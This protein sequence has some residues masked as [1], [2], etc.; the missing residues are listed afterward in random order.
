MKN[1]ALITG[2]TSGIGLAI[3]KLLFQ[4]G[5]NLILVG[6]TTEKLNEARA[7]FVDYER[8]GITIC[9]DLSANESAEV[10]YQKC[11]DHEVKILVNNAG[12]GEFGEHINIPIKKTE[13]MLVLNII[14]LTKLCALFGADFKSRHT[15]Y[16]L[17]IASTA[18]YQPVPRF[19]AYAASKSYV[20]N[21]TEALSK[22]L[23]DYNVVVTCLSPGHTETSFFNRA[24]I[25]DETNGF[26]SMKTRMTAASVA[27]I[28]VDALFSRKLSVIPGGRNKALAFLNK[29]STRN[30]VASISKKLLSKA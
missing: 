26:F 19:S 25:G 22:E 27:K 3:G 5:H 18:A 28:G 30:F 4:L 2:G 24:G 13:Q 6:S 8:R 29:I 9:Q 12:V 21:F 23:E 15:G 16:I 11:K 1:T 10:S 20:L 7:S 17:N 14:T